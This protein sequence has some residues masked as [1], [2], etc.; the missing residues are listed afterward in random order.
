MFARCAFWGAAL[1][2]EIPGRHRRLRGL[3]LMVVASC[4]MLAPTMPQTTQAKSAFAAGIPDDV[5]SQ[6]V[7]LGTG[8]NYSSRDGAEARALQECQT[9][10]DAPQSTRDLCK[11]VDHFDGRCLSVSLDPKAG[12]PGFGWAVADTEDAANDQ[13]LTL[14]RQSAGSDRAP[15]CVVSL[16]EC[17]T[18]SGQAR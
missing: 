1:K 6:G 17:D 15:Y 16:N 3:R 9:Q 18:N 13:A 11:I 2:I 14:C 8:Y 10:Q 5:A 7:A 4:C 12:T